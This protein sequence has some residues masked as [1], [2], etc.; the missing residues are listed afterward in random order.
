LWMTVPLLRV[1]CQGRGL[2]RPAGR[3]SPFIPGGGKGGL[4]WSGRS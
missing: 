3:D 2:K 4:Y 1:E